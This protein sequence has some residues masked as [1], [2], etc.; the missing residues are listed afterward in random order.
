MRTVGYVRDPQADADQ[1]G[2]V[3]TASLIGDEERSRAVLVAEFSRAAAALRRARELAL[4]LEM[5][6]EIDAVT[7]KVESMKTRVEARVEQRAH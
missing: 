2:Y 4:A 6:D 5:E 1:Q 3:E 7:E